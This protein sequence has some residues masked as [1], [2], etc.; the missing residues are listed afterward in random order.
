MSR[1]SKQSE[2]MI[3]VADLILWAHGEGFGLTG[4]DLW[5]SPE[6]CIRRGKEDSVH[7]MRLAI[8]LNL[9]IDGDYISDGE[10]HRPMGE[11]WKSLHDDACWGGDWGDGNHYSFE[12]QGQK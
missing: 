5:R 4:G 1:R 9:I 6:E 7:G 2:F 10:A 11:F 12:H 3:C 8:D